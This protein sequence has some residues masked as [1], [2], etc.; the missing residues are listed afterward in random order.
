MKISL[1]I[2]TMNRFDLTIKSCAQVLTDPRIDDIVIVD[3][4]STD[5]SYEKLRDYFA[6][7]PHV[8]VMQQA[9][10]RGMSRNKADAISYAKNEWVAIIDSDNIVTPK[11]FDALPETLL[12][13]FIYCPDFAK[14]NFDY[15]I[16]GA[17]A[18]NSR[19][20]FEFLRLQGYSDKLFMLLNT[21]NYVV[22]RD[23]YVWIYEYNPEMKGT[24]TIWF[25]YL[26]LK[27]GRSLYVV[28]D[29]QYDH[30]VHDGSGF[31]QDLNYNMIQAEKVRKMIMAL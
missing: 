3:D 23:E 15:R 19:N 20:A 31:T 14:P 11:Y 25:N 13:G 29:M 4:K 9:A 17:M 30:L 16:F 6:P 1:A 26:W 21:C 18:I 24:D 10:N 5:G 7:Y 8:R 27:S 2:T 12:P 22:N 28:K